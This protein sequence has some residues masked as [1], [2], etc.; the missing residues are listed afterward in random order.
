ME[1]YRMMKTL[2]MIVL[3]T[4]LAAAPACSKKKDSENKAPA[5]TETS[6]SAAAGSAAAGSDTGS[7]AAGS[8]TG[9]AAAGS[10]TGSA[11]ATTPAAA[12]DYF[13]IAAT[14]AKPKPDDPV[15]IKFEKFKVTK[16]TFDPQKIEGGTATIEV[17]LTSLSSGSAKRD[18]HLASPAYL[19]TAKFAT[20][21]ID[22]GNVKKKD[23]NTY[24]ADAKVKL[25]DIEKTYPVTFEVVEAKD[26]WI[27]IK[28][29]H[30]FAR[31]DFK[32]GKANDPEESV[33]E[34]LTAMLQLTLKKT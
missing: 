23:G 31:L 20:L 26:D 5:S 34:E 22:V 28:G 29:E 27:R 33:G 7:A 24:S 21:T 19:D 17:D 32:V 8:D 15:H 1:S 3:A 6:G 11:A 9:S 18:G 2:K 30:K 25:R 10:D 13:H 14:H 16:A 12:A 4:V